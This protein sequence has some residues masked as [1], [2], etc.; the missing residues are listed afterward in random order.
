VPTSADGWFPCHK[1]TN[2]DEN[3]NRIDIDREQPCIGAALFIEAVRGD[4]RANLMFRL[5]VASGKL[6]PIA[7]NRSIPVYQNA[8]EFV[9]STRKSMLTI[10]YALLH[11]TSWSNVISVEIEEDEVSE[12]HPEVLAAVYDDLDNNLIDCD[13]DD[14]EIEI[15]EVEPEEIL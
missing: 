2:F 14:I 13:E 1:T 6:D 4:C 5:A 3:G 10:K 7:L 12:T 8:A 15:L 11:P 9:K